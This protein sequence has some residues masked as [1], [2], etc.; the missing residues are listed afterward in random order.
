MPAIDACDDFS[1][2]NIQHRDFVFHAKYSQTAR[3]CNRKSIKHRRNNH[4]W[5]DNR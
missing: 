1:V 5:I 4:M 3:N 2:L